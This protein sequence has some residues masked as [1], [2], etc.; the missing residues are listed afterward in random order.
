MSGFF[1]L[2]KQLLIG[3]T[4]WKFKKKMNLKYLLYIMIM[5]KYNGILKASWQ[6]KRESN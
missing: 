6:R 4:K 2:R 1:I 5:R 3:L